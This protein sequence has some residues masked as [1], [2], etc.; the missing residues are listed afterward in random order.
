MSFKHFLVRRLWTSR[1]AGATARHLRR[2]R[3]GRR[4]LQR[5]AAPR[6]PIAGRRA[7]GTARRFRAGS[8]HRERRKRPGRGPVS[9]RWPS[10]PIKSWS[11]CC[12]SE[13]R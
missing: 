2:P 13:C 3:R 1:L 6:L 12:P 7:L 5:C 10:L 4:L 11:R 9:V 8:C